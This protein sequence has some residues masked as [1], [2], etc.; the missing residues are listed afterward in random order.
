MR[1]QQT[2][3]ECGVE[4]EVDAVRGGLSALVERHCGQ[5][6]RVKKRTIEKDDMNI[7]IFASII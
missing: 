2:A 1:K 7:N 6:L 4:S 5:T 3:G